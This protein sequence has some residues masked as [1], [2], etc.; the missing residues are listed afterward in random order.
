MKHVTDLTLLEHINIPGT[1]DA[2]ACMLR[3]IAYSTRAY[4]L[5]SGV[6]G[7]TR[8]PTAKSTTA[9]FAR[10][11]TFSMIL[12]LRTILRCSINRASRFFNNLTR[13]YD[14]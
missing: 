7:T 10:V 4:G 8:G 2:A 13:E 14:C 11:A 1:H 5:P 12:V 9:R 6:K 3:Q